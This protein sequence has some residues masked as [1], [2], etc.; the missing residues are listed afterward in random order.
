MSQWAPV[1]AVG[2]INLVGL[3]AFFG[4]MTQRLKTTEDT[5][6][7]LPAQA[8]EQARVMDLEHLLECHPRTAKR[9]TSELQGIE[10]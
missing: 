8:K 6:D 9:R 3:A 5:V 2:I 10:L 1:A 4:A 7:R